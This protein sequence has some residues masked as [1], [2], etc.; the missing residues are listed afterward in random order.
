MTQRELYRAVAR[1]TGES[2]STVS[3]NGF[4]PLRPI[5]MERQPLMVDWDSIDR[6]RLAAFPQRTRE[7]R[8]VV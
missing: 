1:A 2:L 6:R 7:R 3:R 5:P 8:P 4:V